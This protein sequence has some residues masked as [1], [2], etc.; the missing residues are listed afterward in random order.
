[1]TGATALSATLGVAGPTALSGTLSVAGATMMDSTLGVAG[2]T[3]LLGTLSVSGAT[4]M[5]S[6]LN[7]GSEFKVATDK[8]RVTAVNGNTVVGGNLKPPAGLRE[9]RTQKI[10][11]CTTGTVP[12]CKRATMRSKDG[13]DLQR[14]KKKKQES[15]SHGCFCRDFKTDLIIAVSNSRSLLQTTD[16]LER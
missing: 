16:T 8:F 5:D 15:L 12:F 4:T 7:V 13:G 2:A 11:R 6:T 1:V 9:D 14:Q 3:T 10:I